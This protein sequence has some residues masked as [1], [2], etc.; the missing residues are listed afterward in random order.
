MEAARMKILP[1][2][3][4]IREKRLRRGFGSRELSAK[5]GMCSCMVSIIETR[6]LPVR[7]ATA[8]AIS[9]ALNTPIEDLFFVRAV[10]DTGE[11]K[12]WMSLRKAILTLDEVIPEP[13]DRMVDREHLDIALAW[14]A[15]K[16]ELR[17]AGYEAD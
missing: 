1:K 5:A 7:P 6:G 14:D 9:E 15:V 2:P 12:K 11:K 4:A 8:T 16:Q 17:E 13:S 10:A 3:D